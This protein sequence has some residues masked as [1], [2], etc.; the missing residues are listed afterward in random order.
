M[1]WVYAIILNSYISAAAAARKKK[2]DKQRYQANRDSIRKASKQYHKANR[3]SR[4]NAMKQYHE[5]NRDSR[6]NA[7]KQYNHAHSEENKEAKKASLN[8]KKKII[9][10]T[11]VNFSSIRYSSKVAM[12]PGEGVDLHFSR[13]QDCPEANT[14]LNHLTTYKNHFWFRGLKFC[15]LGAKLVTLRST[16]LA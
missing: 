2:Y 13:H 6:L 8:R 12:E 11:R 1:V 16:N 15:Y 4:L 7:M 14:V 10:S 3:E 9:E 5:A